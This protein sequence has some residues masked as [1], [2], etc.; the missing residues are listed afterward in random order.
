MCF[1]KP[2]VKPD[3]AVLCGTPSALELAPLAVADLYAESKV[4]ANSGERH[5][6]TKAAN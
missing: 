3:A 6:S 4:G 5:S 1:D 2:E